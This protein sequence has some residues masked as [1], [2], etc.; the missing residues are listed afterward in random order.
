[1]YEGMI[2]LLAYLVDVLSAA[3]FMLLIIAYLLFR[4]K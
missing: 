1:M 3:V 4:E 2:G